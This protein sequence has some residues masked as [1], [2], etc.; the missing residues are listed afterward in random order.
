[1]R[2]H[3]GLSNVLACGLACHML[4]FVCLFG[5][6]LFVHA[7]PEKLRLAFKIISYTLIFKG[8][9]IYWKD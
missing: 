5:S 3:N 8:D 9:T 2:S 4:V 6:N 1:M 7:K